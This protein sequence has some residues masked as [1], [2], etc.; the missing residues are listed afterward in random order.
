MA[1]RK[2]LEAASGAKIPIP[3]PSFRE[4]QFGDK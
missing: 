3:A 4:R 1:E 2:M